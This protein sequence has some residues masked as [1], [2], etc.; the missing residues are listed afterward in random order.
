MFPS[1]LLK[2]KALFSSV[3]CPYFY[4]QKLSDATLAIDNWQWV[5]QFNSG[6]QSI[7]RSHTETTSKKANL[8]ATQPLTCPP[9][10]FLA[11][12]SSAG[13]TWNLNR[14][15]KCPVLICGRYLRNSLIDW[16]LTTVC[17]QEGNGQFHEELLCNPEWRAF[18]LTHSSFLISVQRP[19]G[20]IWV[21]KLA[22]G[23]SQWSMFVPR[24]RNNRE[25]PTVMS[26]PPSLLLYP[27]HQQYQWGVLCETE[28]PSPPKPVGDI[29]QGS[30]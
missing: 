11:H 12:T 3:T 15:P 23:K 17:L 10:P 30:G 4:H 13:R 22:S 21:R 9:I 8:G 27:T 25:L 6:P 7:P 28:L 14:V 2:C 19:Q 5:L 24:K 26:S 20:K 16:W 1:S 18:L 29:T